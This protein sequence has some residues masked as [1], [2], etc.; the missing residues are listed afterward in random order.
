MSTDT[1]SIVRELKDRQDILDCL[2]RYC[3]GM[4][5]FDRELLRS[6]YHDD[7]L[8]DHGD[9]VGSVDDF[10]DF[11]FNYHDTYQ[12]RTVHALSNHSCELDGDVA[13]TETYWTFTAVNREAPFHSRATGRYIDRLEKRD[14][15]WAIAARICVVTGTDNNI[16]PDGQIGDG[17]FVPSTR[18]RSDPSYM[19]PLRVDPARITGKVAT[20]AE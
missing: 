19:R 2:V 9:F 15:R 13:H 3:R 5:R 4:D 6:A 7:A 18:D 17:T 14:G 10:I 16:D 12:T 1:D 8:D 11:Y 20:P